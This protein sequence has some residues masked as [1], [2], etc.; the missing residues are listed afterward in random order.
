M[1][2]LMAFS[3]CGLAWNYLKHIEGFEDPDSLVSHFVAVKHH[4]PLNGCLHGGGL[5][6]LGLLVCLAL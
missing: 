4:P 5:P 6:A 3:Q 2:E 1:S